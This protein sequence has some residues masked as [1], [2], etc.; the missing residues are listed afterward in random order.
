MDKIEVQSKLLLSTPYSLLLIVF[1]EI[2]CGVYQGLWWLL[3][4]HMY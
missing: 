4:F 3:M 2:V 1:L